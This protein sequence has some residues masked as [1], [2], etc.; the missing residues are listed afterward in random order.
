MKRAQASLERVL[1][2]YEERGI[3]LDRAPTV[4]YK[5]YESPADSTTIAQIRGEDMFYERSLDFFER[6]F[7][8][9]FWREAYDIVVSE[10]ALVQKI[11]MEKKAI[12]ASVEQ[13]HDGS[14]DIM[15]FQPYK[16]C[17]SD[18]ID[19]DEVLAHEVWH[20]IEQERDVMESQP[21]IVEGAATYA[22]KRYNGLIC[23]QPP[24]MMPTTEMMLYFGGANVIHH[25]LQDS[26]DPFNELLTKERRDRMQHELAE[27]MTPVI[28][29]GYYG[30][31]EIDAVRNAALNNIL[32]M[33]EFRAIKGNLT[34]ETL[35]D[36]YERMGAT[37]LASEL[38]GQG[39]DKVLAIMKRVGF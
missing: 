1:R 8:E 4:A 15:L 34:T 25:E 6:R 17:E 35:I 38:R 28:V 20:L 30:S 27:R 37:K 24:E 18:D 16:R 5:D 3:T 33:P 14:A 23:N 10:E 26:D 2:F 12:I 32:Q 19:N 36:A 31:M 13:A 39:L 7:G 29:K 21:F 22:M 9:R 11:A